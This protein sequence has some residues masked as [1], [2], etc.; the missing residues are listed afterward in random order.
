MDTTERTR[1][2]D[3]M[4]RLASGDNAA[5]FDLHVEFGSWMA[6]KMRAHVRALNARSPGPDDL[7][8]LVLDGWMALRDC[9]GA[10]DPDGGALPWNWARHRLHQVAS[11]WVGQYADELDDRTVTTVSHVVDIGDDDRCVLVVL[12]D[13]AESH[14]LVAL[15][16]DA[17]QL[18]SSER[19]RVVLLEVGI[20]EVMGDPS[21][22][23]T[24]ASLLDM[25]PEAVRKVRSRARS[26]L[27]RLAADDERFA[28]V[29]TLDPAA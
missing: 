21:P 15:L 8:G 6:A 13:V 1:L 10:W 3:L 12:D 29:P 22:S 25:S 14:A 11:A 20:Q 26:R 18:I 7:E 27:R 28:D 2:N 19:D 16:R 23:T 17:L 9:A 24:V 4:G 5:V